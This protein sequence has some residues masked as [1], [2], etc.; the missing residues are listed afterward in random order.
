MTNF[1]TLFN[2]YKFPLAGLFVVLLALN[3]CIRFQA[4]STRLF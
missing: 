2:A 4:S 1:Q 3:F